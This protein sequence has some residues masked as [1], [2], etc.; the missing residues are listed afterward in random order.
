MSHLKHSYENKKYRI[1]IYLD[2]SNRDVRES[3]ERK[4]LEAT[5]ENIES[6]TIRSNLT[7]IPPNSFGIAQSKGFVGKHLF[8]F[9]SS[10]R[11]FFFTNS[12]LQNFYSRASFT[13]GI[14]CAS[15]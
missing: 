5:L 1:Y 10:H 3:L 14:W 2:A 4:P 13:S 11:K 8:F 7:S 15:I 6:K 9:K 12:T